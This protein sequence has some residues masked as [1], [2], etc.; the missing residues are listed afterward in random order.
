[1]TILVRFRERILILFK[2][3]ANLRLL[4]SLISSF[5]IDVIVHKQCHFLAIIHPIIEAH[6]PPKMMYVFDPT[7][8]H[9]FLA[10]TEKGLAGHAWYEDTRP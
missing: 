6:L 7:P 2:Q 3:I 9:L 1:M 4:D 8:D 10:A 5:D